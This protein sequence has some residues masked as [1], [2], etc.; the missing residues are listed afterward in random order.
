M[1]GESFDTAHRRFVSYIDKSREYYAA[2]G[3]EAPY[4]WAR[5]DEVPFTPLAK[6]L[7]ES[8]IGL[9]TTATL[10]ASDVVPPESDGDPRDLPGT[11]HTGP[12]DPPPDKLYTDNR[13]WDKNATH[14]NDTES[15]LPAQRLAE[16]V[17]QGRLGGASP[18]FYAVPTEYSQRRTRE[19]DAPDVA[20]LMR[21]DGVDVA[22]LV[23]L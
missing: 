23:P 7:A 15:F 16:C 6:P 22:M 1:M 21:E 2:Q 10:L 11:V 8:R 18:R 3:Y 12:T 20:R 13:A 9:V 17:E 5:F 14:T 19:N 4:R